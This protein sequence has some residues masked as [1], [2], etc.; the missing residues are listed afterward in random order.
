MVCENRYAATTRKKIENCDLRLDRLSFLMVVGV[1][2][3]F[4]VAIT[5]VM[6]KLH[7]EGF[8]GNGGLQEFRKVVR[9]ADYWRKREKIRSF[10][11][12]LKQH[13]DHIASRLNDAYMEIQLKRFCRISATGIRCKASGTFCSRFWSTRFRM[14]GSHTKK[15]GYNTRSGMMSCNIIKL[16][17]REN[18][19]RVLLSLSW[20]AGEN[21]RNGS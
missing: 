5:L 21:S 17:C 4:V 7:Q 8:V 12:L 19:L 18:S 14:F 10:V 20:I 15:R 11:N 3:S 9:P 16:Q 1:M 6:T 2:K 13:N